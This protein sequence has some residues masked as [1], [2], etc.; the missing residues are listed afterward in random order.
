MRALFHRREVANQRPKRALGMSLEAAY[1]IQKS[2]CNR[3][4]RLCTSL[5]FPLHRFDL[6][7]E[8]RQRVRPLDGTRAPPGHGH[9]QR[10]ARALQ[11]EWLA[12]RQYF[13]TSRVAPLSA[14]SCGECA[15]GIRA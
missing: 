1:L 5:G 8:L 6:R 3:C 4:R 9:L 13:Q 12:D 2:P 7:L 10:A 11:A 14:E 15:D